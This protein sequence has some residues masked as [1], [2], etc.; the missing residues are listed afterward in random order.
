MR[1][2]SICRSTARFKNASILGKFFLEY[3]LHLLFNVLRH[4][5]RFPLVTK[6]CWEITF[7]YFQK[8]SFF[9]KRKDH[10]IIK[11][12]QVIYLLSNYKIYNIASFSSNQFV[13]NLCD[14]SG[15]LF[16]DIL[17]Q[18]EEPLHTA[19]YHC[20]LHHKQVNRYYLLVCI[21]LHLRYL[22]SSKYG[23]ENIHNTQIQF[24]GYVSYNYFRM[25]KVS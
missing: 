7:F 14:K 24:I 17:V 23:K 3:L 5:V 15:N 4:T 21:F 22:P 8:Y 2:S 10:N 20:I 16:V 11:I 1:K 6:R 25:A 9:A 18:I 19:N 13:N 12:F